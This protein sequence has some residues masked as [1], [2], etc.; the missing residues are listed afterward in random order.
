MITALLLATVA[1][2]MA[3]MDAVPPALK[4]GLSTYRSCLFAEIDKQ[5]SGA[6]PFS[7]RKVLANCS[8]VRR[9]ELRK[10]EAALGKTAGQA[11]TQRKF[12]EMDEEVWTIV[13][14]LRAKRTG[15]PKD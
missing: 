12:A 13:G 4:A 7:E 15:R 2:S 6:S 10:A 8:A 3:A 1:T 14:H 11:E 5:Y 9:E